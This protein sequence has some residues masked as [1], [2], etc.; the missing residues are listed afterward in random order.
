MTKREALAVAKIG[1]G[2]A[3]VASGV[4]TALGKGVLGTYCRNHRMT[5]AGIELGKY[6]IKGGTKMVQDGL[7]EWRAARG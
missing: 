5:R 4:L 1:L 6:S 7:R 2:S 3:R